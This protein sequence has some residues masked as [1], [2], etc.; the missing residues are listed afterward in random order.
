MPI[1]SQ[2][3]EVLT[4]WPKFSSNIVEDVIESWVEAE[5]SWLE[6][7][8]AGW[9][10]VEVDGAGWR[11]V[12]GLVIPFF[13]LPSTTDCKEKINKFF[14]NANL[15][16]VDCPYNDFIKYATK[17]HSFLLHHLDLRSTTE[18]KAARE[19]IRNFLKHV[20]EMS[21]SN[22]IC[23]ATFLMTKNG[24]KIDTE[25]EFSWMSDFHP[26]NQTKFKLGYFV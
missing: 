20:A 19:I 24:A 8:A 2:I 18:R 10:W 1:F 11:W 4:F 6:V 23:D 3:R 16:P 15:H 26:Q 25:V 22:L 7:D 21:N 17:N 12:R 9:S 5:I 13:F 14:G